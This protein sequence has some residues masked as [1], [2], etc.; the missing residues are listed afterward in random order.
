MA[1]K[2]VPAS[3]TR[4]TGLKAP[5]VRL[6][7]LRACSLHPRQAASRGERRNALAESLDSRPR[8]GPATRPHEQR[9]QQRYAHRL[10]ATTEIIIQH[11]KGHKLRE[12]QR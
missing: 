4:I 1:A 12:H 6:L 9:G 5:A 7:H 11:S 2:Q 8:G 10:P 3:S